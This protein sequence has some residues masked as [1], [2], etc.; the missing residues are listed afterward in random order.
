MRFALTVFP[1]DQN[2]VKTVQKSEYRNTCKVM[3]GK[4]AHH[5]RHYPENHCRVQVRKVIGNNDIGLPP[6]WLAQI[7]AAHRHTNQ[8]KPD[9]GPGFYKI[10]DYAATGSAQKGKQ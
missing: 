8:K 2:G 7:M 10:P 9:V 4:R 6:Y 3:P 1:V 5:K